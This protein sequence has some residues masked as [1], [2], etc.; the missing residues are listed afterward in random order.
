MKIYYGT[1]GCKVNQYE[2][3]LIREN[4]SRWGEVTV[5][6]ISK[7]SVAVI[8][9]CAVTAEAESKSRSYIRKI[10]KQNPDCKIIITGCYAQRKNNDLKLIDDN[11]VVADNVFKFNLGEYWS[12]IFSKNAAFKTVN[13]ISSFSGH[14]RAFVK[15]QDGC[16]SFCSYCIVPYLRPNLNSKP[17]REVIEEIESLLK[18]GY[19]EIVLCGIRMGK[20]S[21]NENGKNYNLTDMLRSIVKIKGDFRI[22]LSSLEIVDITEDLISLI[23]NSNKICHHLHLPIQSGSDKVLEKMRRPYTV[24]RF[25]QITENLYKKLPKLSI[26]TDVMVGFPGE[27]DKEFNET[28][29]TIK[30][31]GFSRLH[32]FPFS[33]RSGTDAEKYK[34]KPN[35]ETVKVRTKKLREL[36]K[37]LEE[38]FIEKQL[39]FL[40]RVLPESSES[41]LTDSYIR[42]KLETS[43]R[44][45]FLRGYLKREH[46]SN[47]LRFFNES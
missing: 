35:P 16:D 17:V 25:T 18:S 45:G 15:I 30:G 37:K 3:E 22:R 40:Q 31:L 10:R 9:T 12:K 24:K 41:G 7:C 39:P 21:F 46:L 14:S 2:T 11:S 20:Y 1:L 47:L 6:D 34:E 33:V 32:I 29:E 28:Y 27:T 5:N 36:H 4:L 13:T 38:L 43:N 42:V 19:K 8:N 23:K 26:S 44:K